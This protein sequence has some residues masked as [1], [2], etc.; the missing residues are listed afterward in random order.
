MAEKT[1]F[2]LVGSPAV[3]TGAAQGIGFEIGRQL[4]D[5]GADLVIFDI[6]GEGGEGARA[7]LAAEFPERTVL[8]YEGDVAE[9]ADWRACFDL[10]KRE[11]GV[12]RILVNDALHNEL[13]P[14][15]RMSVEEW[16][17]IFA[18]ISRGTFLGCRELARR[19]IED[20]LEGPAA[21]VNISTLNYTI[22][23]TGLSAYCAAKAS[24]SQFTKAAA[25]EFA[26]LGIRVN[27]IAPGLVRTPLAERFFGESPEVPEAFVARTPMRRVGM[28][29]DQARAVVFLAGEASGWI[30][31]VTLNVDGGMHTDGV[32]DNW[33]LM[34]GP[35]GLSDPEP[36]EWLAADA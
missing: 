8:A 31:G 13:R 6:N 18:V 4:L 26:P 21:I 17:R 16:E 24:V 20:G 28:P 25:M 19:F 23:T 33:E 11:L 10:A 27:A 1:S 7:S 14:I 35:L 12:P 3:V 32:P 36:S 22:P 2:D 15:A 9:E 30:T 29:I 34:K 5:H